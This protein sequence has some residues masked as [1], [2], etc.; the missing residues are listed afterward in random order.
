MTQPFAVARRMVPRDPDEEH[1]VSTPL[2][3]LVDLTLVSRS[4]TPARASITS[5]RR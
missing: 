1:R 3:L 4:R 5:S 2:E